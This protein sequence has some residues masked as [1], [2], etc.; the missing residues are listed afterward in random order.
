VSRTLLYVMQEVFVLQL[1]LFYV[2]LV[3][4]HKD[5]MNAN[6]L[7]NRYVQ[8]IN[9]ISVLVDF[10]LNLL[11]IVYLLIWLMVILISQE[12]KV[13]LMILVVMK[14]DLIY[15]KMDLA[16]RPLKNVQYMKDAEV[17]LNLII[18]QMVL[19]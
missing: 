17:L 6:L 7:V 18:A 14:L 13:I 16:E 15:V 2:N 12:N 19:V 8:M 10:V 5:L 3:S 11:F 1:N 4:V 9:L